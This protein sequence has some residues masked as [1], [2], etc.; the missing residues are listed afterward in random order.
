MYRLSFSSFK[1]CSFS[2]ISASKFFNNE[3]RSLIVNALSN[4]CFGDKGVSSVTDS[5]NV[6]VVSCPLCENID[7][8]KNY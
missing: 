4:D 5:S 6:V 1:C 2:A 3:L 7:E 8:I